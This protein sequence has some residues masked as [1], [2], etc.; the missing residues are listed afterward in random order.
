M[1]H[2]LSICSSHN[3]IIPYPTFSVSPRTI[4]HV[5]SSACSQ[6][7]WHLETT[8]FCHIQM[9]ERISGL[10]KPK[11]FSIRRYAIH[12]FWSSIFLTPVPFPSV[13]DVPVFSVFPELKFFSLE[14]SLLSKYYRTIWT[15]IIL[16]KRNFLQAL[17]YA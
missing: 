16:C 13:T 1:S 6:A 5:K 3:E 17:V 9:I 10:L 7:M 8:K 14:F 15:V 4:S 2:H 11:V 12:L